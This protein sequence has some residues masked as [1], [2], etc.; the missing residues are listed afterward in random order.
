MT[1][2]VLLFAKPPFIGLSKTRLA[3][4]LGKAEARRIATFTLARTL[5]AARDPRW[6]LTLCVTPRSFL[7]SH[8][9]G[10]WP[11]SLARID[12]GPGDLG[13]RL[14]RAHDCSPRGPILFIGADCP[15]L[16]P[17]LIWAGFRALQTHD[18]V[19]GPAHDGGFWLFGL[20]KALRTPAPFRAVRWS[21]QH[22]LADVLANLPPGHR[23]AR[24]P[25]LLDI[26]EAT[27]WRRWQAEKIAI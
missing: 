22:A 6:H 16:A 1:R 24:L 23:V 20:N 14:L 8:L 19:A 27:D 3:R 26:D 12:Q 21:T 4:S 2:S 9:G 18:A 10:L 7:Q 11:P 5:R 13:A 15:D 25:T 17:A